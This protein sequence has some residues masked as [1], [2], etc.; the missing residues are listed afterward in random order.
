MLKA[1]N[2]GRLDVDYE[3]H[4]R[5]SLW[6]VK[7]PQSKLMSRFVLYQFWLGIYTVNG[8]SLYSFI[9]SDGDNSPQH[10]YDYL[11]LIQLIN[12]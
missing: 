4:V 7:I 2:S 11:S 5:L 1:P 6:E 8:T 10:C 9:M 12:Y 3:H